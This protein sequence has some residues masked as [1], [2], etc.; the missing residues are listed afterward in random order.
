[1]EGWRRW[2]R[3]GVVLGL[4]LVLYFLIPA[5]AHPGRP[6]VVRLAICVLMVVVLA[7]MVVWQVRQQMIDSSRHVDGL[8]I[9]LVVAVLSF[10]TAF[11]VTDEVDPTQISGLETRLD[12]LYF[13]MTTLLTVGFG[14]I[15]AAGQFARG[16]VLVQ[17]VFNVAV[18][19]TAATAISRRI[20]EKALAHAESLRAAGDPERPAGRRR[21]IRRGEGGQGRR[22]HRNPT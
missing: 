3:L 7:V 16:I 8:L 4:L 18:I 2:L 17:M 9:A 11:Y 14:D 15:H 13:T 19:A 22:T 21:I 20:R 12:S 10:A 6:E 5:T 1:V